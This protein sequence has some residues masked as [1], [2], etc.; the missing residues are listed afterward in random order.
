MQLS[1]IVPTFNS[2]NTIQ[3]CLESI[4]SQSFQDFEVVIVDGNSS[5]KTIEIVERNKIFLPNLQLISEPDKGIY[6][7]MNKGIKL[8][9]GEWLFF[10][11]SDDKLYNKDVLLKVREH[12][13][14]NIEVLYGDVYS[15]RFNGRYAGEFDVIK[16]LH[17]NIC[18]QGIIFKKSLFNKIGCFNLKYKSHAD[19]DH[20]IRWFVNPWIKKKYVDTIIAEYADGGFSS[21]NED[22]A[23]K[24]DKFKNFLKHGWYSLSPRILMKL[25]KL[26]VKRT[27][28]SR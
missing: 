6:D 20:N 27:L 21:L 10:L 7:A 16:L 22:E 18:H 26:E 23:F 15:S 19:Y 25:V 14:D 3:A 11:G 24:N 17:A 1:I 8:A 5:D 12:F 4:S 28:D 2:E 9:I 13:K